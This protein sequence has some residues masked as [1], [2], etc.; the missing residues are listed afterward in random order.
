MHYLSAPTSPF[1]D[2]YDVLLLRD[3]IA[4]DMQRTVDGLERRWQAIADILLRRRSF[5][6]G[7]SR[8][9]RNRVTSS[10]RPS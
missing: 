4:V 5:A 2:S 10:S 9:G 6:G 7:F 8:A 3:P 1:G